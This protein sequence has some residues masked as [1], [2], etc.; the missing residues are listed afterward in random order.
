MRSYSQEIEEMTQQ[1][2]ANDIDMTHMSSLYQFN[3]GY[4]GYIWKDTQRQPIYRLK[5]EISGNS[6]DLWIY[7]DA[8]GGE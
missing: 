3:L 1:K 6:E 7:E 4:P 5:T 8:P 2:S